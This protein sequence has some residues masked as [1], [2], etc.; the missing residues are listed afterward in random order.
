MSEIKATSGFDFYETHRYFLPGLLLVFLFGYIAFPENGNKFSFSEKI[1]FG[2]LIGFIIHSFG[3]YKWIPGS[4][5]I[6]KEFYKKQRNCG[7][8][9][10]YVRWDPVQ[11]SALT[12]ILMLITRYYLCSTP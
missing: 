10:V 6:R 1:M 7:V 12:L 11:F 2:I 5:K 8:D 3:M 4:T 9:D